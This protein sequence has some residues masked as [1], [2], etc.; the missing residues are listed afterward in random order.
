MEAISKQ[1]EDTTDRANQLVENIPASEDHVVPKVSSY[2]LKFFMRS[3]YNI[4][5]NT[6]YLTAVFSFFSLSYI[7]SQSASLFPDKGDE[8]GVS[9]SAER[10]G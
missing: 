4:S 8:G 10:S 2:W 3:L 1:V 7:T 9:G 5:I 6:N